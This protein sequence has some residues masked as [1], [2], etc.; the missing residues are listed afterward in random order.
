V[1][2]DVF[3]SQ[4]RNEYDNNLCLSAA[5]FCNELVSMSQSFQDSML[6]GTLKQMLVQLKNAATKS[7]LE[8]GMPSLPGFNSTFHYSDL[9]DDIVTLFLLKHN[10]VALEDTQLGNTD[11]EISS[12][13]DIDSSL[14]VNDNGDDLNPYQ[15]D[16]NDYMENDHAKSID[17]E[18]NEHLKFVRETRKTSIYDRSEIAMIE[19]L[20]MLQKS[21]SP[22]YLF[23][24]LTSWCK[25][26][27][28][29]F[30]N[31]KMT[32]RKKFI[33]KLRV[34]A[35]GKHM[36][37]KLSPRVQFNHTL[38]S[39]KLID[40]TCFS[41]KAKLCSILM[42]ENIMQAE[43]LLL[44]THNPFE[45]PRANLMLNDL[46]SG[47][48]FRETWNEMCTEPCEILCPIIFFID[49]GRATKRLSVEP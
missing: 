12:Q 36:S 30:Q 39:G 4:N 45:P 2:V 34:K 6:K 5:R 9:T 41:F 23:D 25:R 7:C 10:E 49:A 47:W 44:N 28:G 43:N 37:N 1:K 26:S 17:E 33:E 11:G 27:S 32:S 22:L 3:I 13:S 42:N 24:Q 15:D 19:L 21:G 18:M 20:E 8:S 40:V 14:S 38:P 46:N 31:Q 48:W 35:F 16:G 29:A